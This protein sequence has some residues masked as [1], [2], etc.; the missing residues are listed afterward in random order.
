MTKASTYRPAPRSVFE[1]RIRHQF[2]LSGP[3]ARTIWELQQGAR[4]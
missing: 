4:S 3:I 2:G 1:R